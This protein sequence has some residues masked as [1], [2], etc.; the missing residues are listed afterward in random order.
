MRC[1][2]L[3][4]GRKDKT[5]SGTHKDTDSDPDPSLRTSAHIGSVCMTSDPK[6]S[7]RR[8]SIK[9]VLSNSEEDLQRR[10]PERNLLRPKT[11]ELGAEIQKINIVIRL[12]LRLL[13]DQTV[14]NGAKHSSFHQINN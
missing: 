8:G 11:Q 2:R 3:G 6:V 1:R 14:Q 10:F 12:K 5:S 4:P 7:A 13:I 9:L